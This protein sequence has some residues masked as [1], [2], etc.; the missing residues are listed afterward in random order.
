MTTNVKKVK[1][2]THIVISMNKVTKYTYNMENV[3]IDLKLLCVRIV[4]FATWTPTLGP[5]MAPATVSIPTPLPNTAGTS[6]ESVLWKRNALS[7]FRFR[8]WKSYGSGSRQY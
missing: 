5:K 2:E 3:I 7:R 8:L 6:P 4:D 1:N